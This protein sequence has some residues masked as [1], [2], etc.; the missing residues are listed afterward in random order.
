MT[1]TRTNP[2]RRSAYAF[3][4]A[5]EEAT[6]QMTGLSRYLDPVTTAVLS[7]LGTPTGGRCLE[8]GPG[9]GSIAHWLA[10]RVGD[11]GEVVAVDIKPVQVPP[12]DR[13]TVLRH[14]IRDGVPRPHNYDL[15]HARLVLLHLPERR[16]VLRALV[17]ALKPG[18]WLV[19]GEFG[20]DPLRVITA[21]T[22]RD[23]QV[24]T[25]VGRAMVASL[26]AAG[27]DMDWAHDAHGAMAAE[28]LTDVFT[29]EYAE[30]WHGG[31]SGAL[32]RSANSVQLEP[33]AARLGL[34][35]ADLAH[36]RRLMTDP[37]FVFMSQ[38][39]V[40]TAGRRRD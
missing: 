6:V 25:E 9:G 7:R 40:C 12:H 33:V 2:V 19:L 36:Y 18:G 37:S 16:E 31:G 20:G 10:D 13:L 5:T 24:F 23:R 21:A 14:D 34:D 30:S 39:F 26:T 29:K 3:D 11:D 38:R 35:K 17:H 22:D 1:D 32:M 28:G 27:A 8:L 15:I 4:N